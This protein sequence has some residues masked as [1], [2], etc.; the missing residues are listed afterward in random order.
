MQLGS[1]DTG[2]LANVFLF[3]RT[4]KEVTIRHG[5]IYGQTTPHGSEKD[6]RYKYTFEW[7]KEARLAPV[8]APLIESAACISMLRSNCW[9]T[10]KRTCRT[11]R[12]LAR[13]EEQ[14]STPID[15]KQV[16]C[17]IKQIEQLHMVVNCWP[18]SIIPASVHPAVNKM[19]CVL[20]FMT[21]R[22]KK[23]FCE[24]QSWNDHFARMI[25]GKK[26]ALACPYRLAKEAKEFLNDAGNVR[27][28]VREF[29]ELTERDPDFENRWFPGFAVVKELQTRF[30]APLW[31][32]ASRFAIQ[33]FYQ[34]GYVVKPTL[35]KDSQV[36]VYYLFK[37]YIM[38]CVVSIANAFLVVERA[39]GLCANDFVSLASGHTLTDLQRWVG[40]LSTLRNM[41]PK[42]RS[43]PDWS[44][45]ILLDMDGVKRA[46]KGESGEGGEG[47]K[48]ARL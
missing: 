38:P 36:L 31:S 21:K 24:S 5:N 17:F 13:E 27:I 33:T 19:M 41:L 44:Q 37:H 34:E 3:L 14:Q 29:I 39:T 48:R 18:L 35:D 28:S 22:L 16:F 30:L 7:A 26:R 6:A 25:D 47:A 43:N 42:K 20:D 10:V 8:L 12:M 4:K 11:F 9:R 40:S 1:L 23:L 15:P 2:V 46:R 45:Q 32:D